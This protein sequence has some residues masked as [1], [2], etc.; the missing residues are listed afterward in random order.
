MNNLKEIEFAIIDNMSKD[1]SI[2]VIKSYEKEIKINVINHN[3]TKNLLIARNLP[4]KSDKKSKVIT[5]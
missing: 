4:L 5:K 1:S 2:Y 3:L